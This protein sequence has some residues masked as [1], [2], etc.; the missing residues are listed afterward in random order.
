MMP[1]QQWKKRVDVFRFVYSN[2]INND[3]INVIK[4][5]QYD[6]KQIKIIKYYITNKQDMIDLISKYLKPT[7]TFNRLPVVDQAIFL[8]A[9]SEY[10]IS[11]I[12]F[13]IIVDQAL[14]TAKYYTESNSIK[15]INAILD[16][17]FKNDCK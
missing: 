6:E 16:K 8:S 9:I 1:K 13:K 15:Y 3:S 11:N 10:K 7:W 14:I 12:D 4:N 5:Q 17:I 2:L